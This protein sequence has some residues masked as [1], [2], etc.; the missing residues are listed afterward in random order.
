M[1]KEKLNANLGK[2]IFF[3]GRKEDSDGSEAASAL[4]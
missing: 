4:H 2:K 1:Y 3:L